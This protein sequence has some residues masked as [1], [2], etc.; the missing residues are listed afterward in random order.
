[1][2][3]KHFEVYDVRWDSQVIA[4][5]IYTFPLDGEKKFEVL[6]RDL[7]K[8][9]YLPKLSKE[10]GEYVIYIQQSPAITTS[11][12]A[13][14]LV[15]FILTII[16]TIW[17]GAILWSP[18]EDKTPKNVFP[19]MM[20]ELADPSLLAFGF[21]YFALPLILILGVHE[22]GHYFAA[23]YH[24][25]NASLP[26]F[27]PIPPFIGPLG[28]FGA[29]ISIRE[30]IPSK[31][32]LLE[33]GAAGPIAGFIVAIPV[34]ILG[35]VLTAHDPIASTS[36]PGQ[37][38][39]YNQ[40]LLFSLFTKVVPIPD[41]SQMHPMAFA[42][43]VGILVTAFNLLPAGQL[44]GGHIARALL[45]DNSRFLS[46][47]V[48]GGLVLMA[49]LTGFYSWGILAVFIMFMGARHPPPL[50]DLSP[51][52]NLDKVIGLFCVVIMI[53]CFHPLP[54]EV[55]NIQEKHYE[56]DFASGATTQSVSYGEVG[57]FYVN[58]TNSG[59]T[60][61]ELQMQC[62]AYLV[63]PG[64]GFD[65]SPNW[66]GPAVNVTTGHMLSGWDIALKGFNSTQD[67]SKS[68]S[69]MV[70]IDVSPNES[71]AMGSGLGL[72]LSIGSTNDPTMAQ[73]WT[74]FAKVTS[75]GF[76]A[77]QSSGEV[78]SKTIAP[79]HLVIKNPGDRTRTFDLNASIVWEDAPTRGW[80]MELN[81]SAVTLGPNEEGEAT[82]F[83][84][85]PEQVFKG[86]RVVV[87]VA[88][89]DRETGDYAV[90]DLTTTVEITWTKNL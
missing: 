18:W 28:T 19:D 55:Q 85:A 47:M 79:Y 9:D 70:A 43:W 34:T 8:V 27:I 29:L 42:G 54:I 46:Y 75:F 66:T 57:H 64:W 56:L 16:S 40:P 6:R 61:D 22:F 4:F 71:V 83:V 1:M 86:N 50:N 78:I 32:A 76:I 49:F 25:V 5:F 82:L 14:N 37:E 35:L 7:K 23:K 68:Q 10:K 72:R 38:M 88:A 2:V 58:V 15:M 26:F 77:K 59:N 67:I 87:R 81:R 3:E 30:P 12:K 13:T 31:R 11:S 73:K 20:M 36:I 33:I 17:A 60:L 89:T 74:L 62:E 41:G 39:L 90:T 21:L 51:L 48:I 45:G 52:K 84:Y 44:D 69:L 53:F 63:E 24:H 80:E 65:A